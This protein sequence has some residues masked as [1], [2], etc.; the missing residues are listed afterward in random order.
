MPNTVIGAFMTGIRCDNPEFIN[1]LLDTKMFIY[2]INR[3]LGSTINQITTGNFK[4]MKFYFPSR[5]E[6]QAIGSY[7]SNLDNLIN[8]HQEKI[9]QLETLKKKLLQDMFI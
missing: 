5:A 9:T 6:Q 1:A 3:N 8:S 4:R 2:E 7:F